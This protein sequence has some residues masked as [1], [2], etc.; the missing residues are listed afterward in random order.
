MHIMQ[1][2]LLCVR[3]FGTDPWLNEHL[4]YVALPDAI[5][6]MGIPRR[7]SHFERND[8]GELSWYRFPDRDQLQTLCK[9]DV[10]RTLNETMH[11][12]DVQQTVKGGDSDIRAYQSFNPTLDAVEGQQPVTKVTGL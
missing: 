9:E 4:A 7:C 2:M 11:A 1:H 12:A 3:E 8:H 5:R 10:Q 6:G